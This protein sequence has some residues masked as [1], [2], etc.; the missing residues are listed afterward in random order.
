MNRSA[1]ITLSLAI[2]AGALPLAAQT[3]LTG[4]VKR[5]YTVIRDYFIRAAEK[6]PE[7]NYGFRPS[8]DV[9]TFAQQVAHVA[10]DQ[11]NLC[12][13]ARGETRKA[14]YTDIED[15]LSKKADLV[16][17]LKA[18]LAYC[19][20]AYDALTDTSGAEPAMGGKRRDEVLDAQL[21]PLA[22]LGA[23]RQ[24]HRVPA[25]EG[26]G[27]DRPARPYGNEDAL[28]FPL[29]GDCVRGRMP[30]QDP[31]DP[32]CHLLPGSADTRRRP[33]RCS[34]RRI[35]RAGLEQGQEPRPQRSARR[36][37]GD[38]AADHGDLLGV[39][40][41]QQEAEVE[42]ARS[43]RTGDDPIA[44]RADDCS[45]ELR[46]FER[47]ARDG[48]DNPISAGESNAVRR[49][50]V[51]HEVEQELRLQPGVLRRRRRRLRVAGQ[52]NGRGSHAGGRGPSFAKVRR[53]MTCLVSTSVSCPS[54]TTTLCRSP[55]R[56]GHRNSRRPQDLAVLLHRQVRKGSCP[57]HRVRE[58]L[59]LSGPLSAFV[60]LRDDQER[61]AGSQHALHLSHV[62]REIGAREVGLNGGDEIELV[63]SEGSS[64]TDACRISTRPSRIPRWFFLR[65]AATLASE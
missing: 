4:D 45:L 36:R 9:R 32:V 13:P 42:D 34:A 7:E 20:G 40:G 44:A 41:L 24:H 54:R 14:A 48:N 65:D 62:R 29:P 1:V 16:P 5:D 61:S 60:R 19:D 57:A 64:D 38:S 10:D 59:V 33:R 63:G 35:C 26:P 23:L 30:L 43:V 49:T 11:Y 27:P 21:E 2:S 39:V 17:A 6:M 12:G 52:Q 18:A 53:V 3:A 28:A 51:E 47:P 25:H 15:R 46:A 22:H 31:I 8:P 37:V 56:P 55:R 58:H 50:L